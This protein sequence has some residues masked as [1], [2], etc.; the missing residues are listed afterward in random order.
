ML[1]WDEEAKPSLQ[2]PLTSG[3]PEG[4]SMELPPLSSVQPQ[5]ATRMLDDSALTSTQPR[6]S[7]APAA[8][9][10]PTAHRVKAADKRIINGQT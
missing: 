9:V 5:A 8:V 10:A 7:A 6:T 3:L 1:T 4:R 2:K